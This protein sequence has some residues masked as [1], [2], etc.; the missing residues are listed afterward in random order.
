LG[1]GAVFF[2]ESAGWQQILAESITSAEGLSKY[3][4]IDVKTVDQVVRQYPMRI[5][6]YY[7]SIIQSA[8]DPLWRQAVPDAAELAVDPALEADPLSEAPQSPV[9]HLIHRY[10]DRV[11][12]MVSSH[13]AMYC[14]HCMR[15][16]RVGQGRAVSRAAIEKGIEYIREQPEVQEVIL[17]GGDPLLISDGRLDDILSR[18][19]RIPHVELLRVHSR[20][21]CT[22]PQRVTNDLAALLASYHPLYL[23]IQFNHPAELTPASM[24]ACRKLADAGIP[25]GSQTVLLKGVNDDP[26]VMKRLMRD[27]LKNRVRPYYLHHTDPVQGTGH[28]R[29]SVERGLEIMRALRGRISGM[30]VPSYMIDLPRGGGKIPLLPQYIKKTGRSRLLVE[31]YEGEMFEYALGH[32]RD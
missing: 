29:T 1:A 11:V 23:N 20:A 12:F 30:G 5:N 9:K 19:K 21:P 28:F 27:L 18:L 3:L 14:R 17:S 6:P 26:R 4:A 25:L 31:N 15:K 24:D 2:S 10:P 8:D 32:G 7:L 22:L 16:R 13:C